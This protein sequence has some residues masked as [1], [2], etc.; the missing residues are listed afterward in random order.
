METRALAIAFV[1]SVG[2]V[3][4]GIAAPLLFGALIATKQPGR[5]FLGYGVGAAL[6][7]LGGLVEAVWGVDAEG[8]SLESIGAPLSSLRRRLEK[9]VE[10][11]AAMGGAHAGGLPP[12]APQTTLPGVPTRG[13]PRSSREP[14]DAAP[15]DSERP[16]PR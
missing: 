9:A 11:A 5:V 1:Y 14:L 16:P 10:G 2:D 15:L 8:R 6:M 7:I 13:V 12:L 3:V 4:G